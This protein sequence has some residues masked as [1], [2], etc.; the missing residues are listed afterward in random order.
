MLAWKR[1][2]TV[3]TAIIVLTVP[4]YAIKESRARAVR[5]ADAVVADEFVG[6]EAC[7]ECHETETEA[8]TGSNHDN[9]MAPADSFSVRGDFE[10]VEFAHDGITTRF[11]RR[12]G[13]YFVWT[14]GPDGEMAEFEVTHTFGWEP[15]QQYL[16]PMPGGRLQNLT[17]A[18]D[19]EREAWFDLYPDHDYPPGDW[20]HWTGAAM[21][22]NGMC[23]ECHSTNLR[24]GYDP[25][26]KSFD[27]TWSEIDVSCEACHGPG[28]RHVAWAEIPEMARP[29][30]DDYGL[31]VSTSGTTNR[32]QVELCAP[33]H[34]RR[35]EL[36]DYD[37]TSIELLDHQIP[38]VL[39]EGLY[40][41]D[42]QI[43]DEVYVYGS[44]T[45]SKMFRNDVRCA[46][47]HD[48][49]SLELHEEGNALCLQCHR[50]DTYD[51]YEHHFHEELTESGEPNE[52]TYCIQCHMPERPYMVVDWRADHS[53][54][55]PRPDL[56]LELGT[57]NACAQ[58]GCHADE[59]D[60]WNAEHYTEWYGKKRR[61][62]YG[63]TF[64]AARRGDAE[65]GPELVRLA[66]DVLY[67]PIVR[68]TAL[69]LLRGYPGDSTTAA[70][71][72]ALQ[73][74]DA[75]IRYT[76]AEAASA[77]T[78][79]A[80]VELLAPL[81]FDAT[82]AVR[83]MA[84]S[85]LAG[86]PREL[87]KPYQAE[88]L[89][90]V[91]EEYI[92]SME[93]S[94]DFAFAGHNLGN[95]YVA[96]GDPQRAESFYR[97]AIRIDDEFLPAK[98]NLAVLLNAQGRNAEA[99]QLVREVLEADPDFGEA[100]YSLALLS[101]EAGRVGE[102]AELLRRSTELMPWRSRAYFNLALAEQQLGRLDA[103]E[104]AF[105]GALG[106]EPGNL[107]YLSA[108]ADHYARRRNLPGLKEMAD[109]LE[110]AHPNAPI[111]AQVRAVVDQVEASGGG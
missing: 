28:S 83:G 69:S 58:S 105:R 18:W 24:K 23:A 79:E 84:A 87:F 19:T 39:D 70:L 30:I 89:E 80:F 37:H 111:T 78:P 3:A 32:Q 109:R 51:V 50:A 96:L 15:L 16:V 63:T 14:E 95:L 45:Q 27:T 103:A 47:C 59:T 40:Y 9:A 48:V 25:E 82:R 75:L 57:P 21:N 5:A 20:L 110:A 38:A 62:H 88:A 7:A 6:R 41:P 73:D 17:V 61:S 64:A 98:M 10:N 66:G 43:L 97:D 52:G 42:G 108:L 54:R 12:D 56:T 86:Q 35:T 67:P 81:L 71:R 104:A 91:L 55:V 8:W 2:G 46:D 33:C 31:L 36:G 101:A 99:E 90:E 93:Y 94:L 13:R 92:S 85:R 34:A 60:Q 74:E 44:F 49:H 76:A 68:A 72:I 107:D 53:I 26:T 1:A 22:W 65:A 100:V 4:L 29:P 106:L 77:A 102:A 11:S